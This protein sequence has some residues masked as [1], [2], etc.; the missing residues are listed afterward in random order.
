MQET[1]LAWLA[2][3]IDGEGCIAIFR[4]TV[5]HRSG[6]VTVV[7]TPYI[8]IVNSSK[9]L[10]EECK[11]ILDELEISAYGFHESRNSTHRLMKRFLIKNR[12][13]LEI[14]LDAIMPYLIGKKDQALLLREY[15]EKFAG[16]KGFEAERLEYFFKLQELKQSD[17][18]TP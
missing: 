17:R 6:N 18:L 15:L 13:S 2:G 7:P 3:V 12:Q 11:S 16:K 9:A 8:T 10:M 4:K 14:L 5:K 1:K